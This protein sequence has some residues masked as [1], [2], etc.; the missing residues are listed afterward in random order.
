MKY[1]RSNI[2]STIKAA[3]HNAKETN[4]SVYVF[5]LAGGYTVQ[6]TP[7]IGIGQDYFLVEPDGHVIERNTWID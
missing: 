3:L 4:M 7:P 2:D 6:K 1:K 5:A